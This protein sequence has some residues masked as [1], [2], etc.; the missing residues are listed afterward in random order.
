M[1]D[2]SLVPDS[3]IN[4]PIKRKRGRPFGSTT[5]LAPEVKQQLLDYIAAGNYIVTALGALGISDD[6]YYRIEEYARQ[7]RREFVEL[8]RE[9]KKAECDAEIA[10]SAKMMLGK[11]HFLPA[12]TFLERRF[13]DRWGRSDRHQIEANVNIRVETINYAE[14]VKQMK[15][16]K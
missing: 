2:T 11:E 8:M 7:G 16:K 4:L 3:S 13:R 12:A 10:I 15:P 14:L 1:P 9:L 6:Y 5:T